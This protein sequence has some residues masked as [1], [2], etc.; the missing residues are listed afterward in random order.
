MFEVPGLVH[1]LRK[2][3]TLAFI[4]LRDINELN[5]TAPR[6]MTQDID[7]NQCIHGCPQKFFQGSNVEILFIL[8]RLLTMQWKW[9]FTKLFTLSAPL[10]CA[11]WNLLSEMFSALLLSEMLYLFINRLI[12][13]FSSI[14][15]KQ[16]QFKN[17]QRSEQHEWW[18]STAHVRA[19]NAASWYFS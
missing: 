2:L 11:G 14:S 1:R 16:S 17:D 7:Q 13:I 6:F 19:K 10:V 9:T 8:F 12:S 3:T 18:V 15:Y 4:F 5:Q